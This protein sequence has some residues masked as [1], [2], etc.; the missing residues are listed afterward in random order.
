MSGIRLLGTAVAT[1]A[2][3]AIQS[4]APAQAADSVE[5][6]HWWTSGGEAA[7]L[8]VLKQRLQQQSVTW[9]D[10]PVAGGGGGAAMT[11]LRARIT[12]G[13]PP[14]A[15][16]MLGYAALDWANEGVAADLSDIAAK[17]GW[18]AA[19][20]KALQAFAKHDGKWIAAPVNVHSANWIYVNKSV[21]DKLA[22]PVPTN[23]DEFIA[24]L[25]KAKAAGVIPI[26]IG[27]QSFQEANLFESVLLTTGGPA[28]YKK[29]MV[30]LDPAALGSPTMKTTFERMTKLRSY[31]DPNFSG[32]DWNLATAM[33]IKG[34]AL[35]QN[36][37]DSAKGEF[38]AAKQVAGKD[39]LCLRFP[40]T[41]GMVTFLTDEFVFFK[42]GAGALDAGQ[43]KMAADIEDP[44]FQ[45][46]F[47]V[48]KGSAPARTDV[49]DAAF[50]ACGKKGIADL[51]TAIAN[52]TLLGSIAY[53]YANPPAVQNAIYDVVTRHFNGQIT[54]DEAVAEMPKAVAAAK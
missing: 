24:L 30:D 26:A 40:G 38:N 5:V 20:P 4:P 23:W 33:V 42:R 18:D 15:S 48:L 46:A 43:A 8:A 36:F 51:K 13:D 50:D 21:M 54:T 44:A 2:L 37:P 27:G 12:A 45:S 52:D 6:L 14:S 35:L 16:Q 7:G 9:R 10:A 1:C 53:G 17:N 28:F 32:R 11:T 22:L 31:V 47:N 25:D 39:Y 34:E 3:L 29:A 49:S 41:E 19:I